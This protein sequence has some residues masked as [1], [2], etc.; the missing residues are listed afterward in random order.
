MADLYEW[1]KYRNV[2]HELAIIEDDLRET[3]ANGN[4]RA[5]AFAYTMLRERFGVDINE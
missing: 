2:V 1:N 4:Q 5:S 3:V